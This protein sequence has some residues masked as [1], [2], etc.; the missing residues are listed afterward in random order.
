ML[1]RAPSPR[2]TAPPAAPGPRLP[3][4][5]L[6]A[7]AA[8]TLL[9][10][11]S[12]S[13]AADTGLPVGGRADSLFWAGRRAV[14]SG[15]LDAACDRFAQSLSLER[16]PGTLLNLAGCEERRG[17]L[18]TAWRL[19]QEA[20]TRMTA[21]DRRQSLAGERVEA[22][23]PR[24]PRLSLRPPPGSPAG[25]RVSC[26]GK[27][28]EMA[29]LAAPRPLDPGK[30]R[31][32]VTATGHVLREMEVELTVGEER[33]LDLVLGPVWTPPRSEAI[34]RSTPSEPPLL[35]LADPAGTRRTAG[36]VLAGTGGFGLLL[37]LVGGALVIHEKSTFDAYCEPSGLCDTR[38]G[39]D[40]G[41]R[42]IMW[43]TAANIASATGGLLLA[44]GII[45]V[46]TAPSPSPPAPAP[47][48]KPPAKA[49]APR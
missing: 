35:P 48:A 46:L 19:Y 18:A 39:F 11:A 41:N 8:F 7:A 44:T 23:A 12:A 3:R 22:L 49:P 25:L 9:A 33:S 28:I 38:A 45:L 20:Q 29:S 24:L 14:E 34:P 40:A 13:A 17:R 32:R 6:A 4:R 1:R 10:A 15:D 36:W 30:H 5:S 21:D 2:R 31:L 42:G 26:D 47:A 37:G 27:P 43:G 16:T